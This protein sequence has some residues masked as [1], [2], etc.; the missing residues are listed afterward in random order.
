MNVPTV[1]DSLC[2]RLLHVQADQRYRDVARNDEAAQVFAVFDEDRYLG[3]VTEKQA[4]LFPGRIFADLTVLRQPQPVAEGFD[5][6]QVLK[7]L[8]GAQ[9]DYLPVIDN[10]GNFVGAVS[11]ISL[12]SALS[13]M[14]RTLLQDRESLIE[15]I[16][17]ELRDH[18][19]AAAVFDTTSEGILVTDA[20]NIILLVNSAFT[21]TTGYSSDEV[22]GR[23]PS[24][25]SSGRHD[26]E[27][28]AA[29]WRSLRET[30]AWS[31]E[32]W[33]RRKNGEIYPEWLHINAVID[34]DGVATN[35]VGIFSDISNQKHVQRHLHQLAYYDALTG[36]PNRQLFYD[37]IEQIIIRARREDAGFSLLFVDFDR[38][39]NINDSLGHN[40]GDKLL[41]VAAQ[42]L[43]E[44]VRESDTVARLGGDEFTVILVDSDSERNVAATATKI[45]ESFSQPLEVENHPIFL[46]ASVGIARYPDDGSDA[47]TLMRNADAAM[48]Q[49]KDEGRSRYCFFTSLLNSQLSDRLDKESALRSSLHGEGLRLVWQPQVRLADRRLVGLEALARW[50]HPHFGDIPP[51]QF[52]PLAEEAGLMPE[53]GLWVL[54]EAS[55]NVTRL[56]E[57]H[58]ID[59]LH[60]ALN[61]SALQVYRGDELKQGI[62]ETLGKSGISLGNF[63]LELTESTLMS[64]GSASEALIKELRD[65][66][67]LIAVDD[68]GTGY[69]NLAYLKRFAVHRL[70]IDQIFVRDL[71]NDETSRQLVTAIVQMAHSLNIQV[72]A[73]GIETE[74]QHAILLALGCDEGQGFLYGR[75]M[76]TDQLAVVLTAN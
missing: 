19:I 34:N 38:F 72:I 21:K 23:H 27:F 8:H 32:I 67:L 15:K 58:S 33:N 71:A 70:K 55:A 4:A 48:Y 75:P 35:Y 13:E 25:L 57:H 31:G 52:I 2:T 24:V 54:K 14:A 22:Q 60:F 51:A 73:E 45:V 66:G 40:F 12:L 59:A 74:E 28:Y 10:A 44:S 39:K 50:H 47:E 6:W 53:F 7:R 69:S 43:R 9:D 61:I 11:Q 36:L 18:R 20:D 49:A 41:Q 17:V 68:F 5:P 56:A 64:R 30:G 62:Q 26:G 3:L 16:G 1:G 29:M 63:E 42:R 65:W 76:E 37:R 46:T